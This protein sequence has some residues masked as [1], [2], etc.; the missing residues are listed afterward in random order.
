MRGVLFFMMGVCLAAPAL[1]CGEDTA[2]KLAKLFYSYNAETDKSKRA[3]LLWKIDAAA[4]QQ[5]EL[6]SRPALSE[7]TRGELRDFLLKV[8][9]DREMSAYVSSA[10]PGVLRGKEADALLPLIEDSQVPEG[11]RTRYVEAFEEARGSTAVPELK[12]LHSLP[13]ISHQLR[14]TIFQKWAKYPD[15]ENLS[16]GLEIVAN[17]QLKIEERVDALER[18]ACFPAPEA[19]AAF[20]KYA[21]DE[22][23]RLS[24]LAKTWDIHQNLPYPRQWVHILQHGPEEWKPAVIEQFKKDRRVYASSEFLA[25]AMEDTAVQNAAIDAMRHTTY[26]E[27]ALDLVKRLASLPEIKAFEAKARAEL[28]K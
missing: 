13:G 6:R 26:P 24:R 15:K 19:K 20:E 22:N 2:T 18:L 10:M 28:V 1:R 25:C 5:L 7:E 9:K 4:G 11:Y 12:R 23:E 16:K 27:R 8:A 14:I 17:T 21:T 3:D